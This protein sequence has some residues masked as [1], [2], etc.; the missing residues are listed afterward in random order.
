V[1]LVNDEHFVLAL[2]WLKTH[3]LGEGADVLY[4]IVGGSVQF[5]DVERRAL[6]EGFART[7]LVAGFVF[8]CSVLAVEYFRED[9]G[10]GGF[11]HTPRTGEEKSMR[12]MATGERV[13][14]GSGHMALPHHVLETLGTVFARGYDKVAH[15][16]PFLLGRKGKSNG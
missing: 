1:H 11:A 12:N 7:A 6:V 5:D 10:A 14:E 3:L 9:A 2:L 15:N 16:M 4:G 13:F 8:G